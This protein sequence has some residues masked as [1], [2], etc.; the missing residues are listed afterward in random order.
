MTDSLVDRYRLPF[1]RFPDLLL[2]GPLALLSLPR[3]F[4]G[5]TACPSFAALTFYWLDFFPFFPCHDLYWLY[6]LPSFPAMTFYW[7]YRL[8]FFPCHDLLL[9]V[10]LALIFLPRPFTG[11][12]SWSSFHAVTFYCLYLLLF[13]FTAM[14]F[15]WLDLLVFFPYR[16][17]LLS[18]ASSCSSF[19]A[20]AVSFGCCS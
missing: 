11:W 18:V 10:P 13:F 9:A 3:P 2:A 7:L 4:T 16:D 1:F 6:R 20:M 12:T 15:Y 14:T 19:A 17:L 8:P 5:F